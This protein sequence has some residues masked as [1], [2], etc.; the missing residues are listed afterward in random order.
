[1]AAD[2]ITAVGPCRSAPCTGEIGA[3][4]DLSLNEVKVLLHRGRKLLK[5]T[6]ARTPVGKEIR[7]EHGHG[8]PGP[9]G[10]R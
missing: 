2:L 3:V 8:F 6:L 1:M 9:G 10:A 4:M 7:G 5:R